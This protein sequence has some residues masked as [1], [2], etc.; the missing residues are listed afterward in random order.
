VGELCKCI[1]QYAQASSPHA[2]VSILL[3]LGALKTPS[4]FFTTQAG[5]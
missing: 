5:N 2:N 3:T 4:Q 1:I